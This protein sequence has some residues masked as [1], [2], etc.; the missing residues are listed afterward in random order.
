M[1]D[2]IIHVVADPEVS[3]ALL[4]DAQRGGNQSVLFLAETIEVPYA[5]PTIKISLPLQKADPSP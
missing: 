2:S 5:Y 1:V 4:Y 3:P